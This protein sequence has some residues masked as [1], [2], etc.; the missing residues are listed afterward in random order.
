MIEAFERESETKNQWLK[1]PEASREREE[2]RTAF[3][4][5]ATPDAESVIGTVF[6]GQLALL[7]GDPAR[8]LSN[9]QI[10]EI[11][12]ENAALVPDQEGGSQLVESPIPI[13]SE[14]AGENAKRLD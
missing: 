13:R 1:S 12:G 6:N 3:D 2:S 5:L 9:L 7:E 11:V 8:A 10:E 4:D 14:L